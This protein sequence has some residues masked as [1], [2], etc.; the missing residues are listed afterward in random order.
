MSA[1]RRRRSCS[2]WTAAS[3]KPAAQEGSAY[4]GH[5]ACMCYHPLHHCRRSVRCL[6]DDADH[7]HNGRHIRLS[8][9]R[10][11]RRRF[12]GPKLARAG[13]HRTLQRSRQSPDRPGH[14]QEGR[15]KPIV[16]KRRSRSIGPSRNTISGMHCWISPHTKSRRKLPTPSQ[17]MAR[18]KPRTNIPFA[19]RGWTDNEG[20]RG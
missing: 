19:S 18:R 13:G 17:G 20:G 7:R 12:Y 14:C 1:S 10:C 15:T 5:F 8:E 4:N 3:A 11:A 16:H 9:N 6:R 2:T